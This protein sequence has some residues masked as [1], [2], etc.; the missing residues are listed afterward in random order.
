[1]RMSPEAL[2]NYANYIGSTSKLLQ[3]TQERPG[4]TF[5]ILTEPGIIHQMKKQSPGSTFIPVAGTEEGACVHCNHCVY[6]K[7]NTMEKLF[8]CMRDKIPEI[9]LP[10]HIARKAR[11]PLGRMLDMSYPAKPAGRNRI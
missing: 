10:D 4:E 1:M 9:T 3:Y 2:L 8:L 6:M 7:L 5:L 11:I